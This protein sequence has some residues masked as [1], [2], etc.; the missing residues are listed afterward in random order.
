MKPD[1]PDRKNA[2][3]SEFRSVVSYSKITPKNAAGKVDFQ[4]DPLKLALMGLRPATT[5]PLD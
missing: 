2:L 5:R 1:G 4:L 3:H